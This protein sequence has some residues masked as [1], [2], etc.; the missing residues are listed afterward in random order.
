M[1]LVNE[2]IVQMISAIVT[3]KQDELTVPF[4]HA[5]AI[6]TF[7]K[8]SLRLELFPSVANEVELNQIVKNVLT[9]SPAK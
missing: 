9:L 8:G 3:S 1:Y 5:V 4:T 7:R 6:T 2:Q